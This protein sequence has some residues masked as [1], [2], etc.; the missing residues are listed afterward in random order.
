MFH[1]VFAIEIREH[2]IDIKHANATMIANI[3]VFILQYS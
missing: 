2:A 3:I 1:N